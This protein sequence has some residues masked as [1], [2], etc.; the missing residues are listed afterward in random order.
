MCLKQNL[1]N[2][3][4]LVQKQIM[5]FKFIQIIHQLKMYL[6][7]LGWIFDKL[8]APLFGCAQT[9]ARYFSLYLSLLSISTQTIID[10]LRICEQLS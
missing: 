4:Q 2:T 5:Y 1:I 9:R 8:G 6:P 10:I 7:C 3:Q